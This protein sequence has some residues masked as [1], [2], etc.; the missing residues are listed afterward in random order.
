[1][2]HLPKAMQYRQAPWAI[3]EAIFFIKL[4]AGESVPGQY[5]QAELH[6]CGFKKF[7]HV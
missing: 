2:H 7:R 4:D 5:L 3:F 6:G 1:M